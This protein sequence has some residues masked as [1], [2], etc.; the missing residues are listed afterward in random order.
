MNKC[1]TV[2]GY[3]NHIKDNTEKCQDCKDA[4]S[5]QDKQYYEKNRQ[6]VLDRAEKYR[7][8]NSE[9]INANRRAARPRYRATERAYRENNRDKIRTR[10]KLYYEEN[11]ERL[12]LNKREYS[13]KNYDRI[14]LVSRKWR[15]AN[16]ESIAQKRREYF[17]NNKDMFARIHR[18]A[19]RKRRALIA[20]NGFEKYTEQQVL[21]TYGTNCHLCDGAIDLKANRQCGKPGWELSLHIDHL[22]PIAKGGPDTLNNVRP[23]HG[24]CNVSKGAKLGGK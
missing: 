12:L 9:T 15:E 10:Y 6:K 2:R 4:K 8:E 17:L 14:K 18:R 22:I 21:E 11:K 23:A 13:K 19:D 5:A 7:E 1:G 20:G 16:R 24:K 3:K